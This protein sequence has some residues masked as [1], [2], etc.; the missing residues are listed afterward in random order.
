MHK[1]ATKERKFSIYRSAAAVA[2][3]EAVVFYHQLPRV[4]CLHRV[5]AL[6]TKGAARLGVAKGA[7]G[8]EALAGW[9]DGGKRGAHEGSIQ[10]QLLAR[11]VLPACSGIVPLRVEHKIHSLLGVRQAGACGSNV[12]RALM[13]TLPTHLFKRCQGGLRL[14]FVEAIDH[15]EAGEG[16]KAVAS[17]GGLQRGE[18]MWWGAASR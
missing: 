9:R 4:V 18:T 6:G 5:P 15:V 2:P 10:P 1:V 7:R 11:K 16:H 13:P 12:P 14:Q 17:R 8:A 3:P